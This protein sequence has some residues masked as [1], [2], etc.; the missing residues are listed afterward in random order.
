MA[1]ACLGTAAMATRRRGADTAGD[2]GVRK[3]CIPVPLSLKRLYFSIAL[4]VVVVV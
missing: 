1:M 3:T 2:T 4:G